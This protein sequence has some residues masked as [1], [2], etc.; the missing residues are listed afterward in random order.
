MI[1][2]RKELKFEGE[3]NLNEISEKMGRERVQVLTER[4]AIKNNFTT[5]RRSTISL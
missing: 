4:I 3:F 2:P 5:K 1:T